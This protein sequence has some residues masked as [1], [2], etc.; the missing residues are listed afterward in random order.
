M[1]Q[2]TVFDS[3]ED[4]AKAL[5]LSTCATLN[6]T[7][8]EYLIVGGWVP[9]I[10]GGAPNLQ[11]PGTRDVDVLFTDDDVER[12]EPAYEALL[13]AGFIPSAKHEFQLLRGLEIG[14]TTFI[15]NVDL[16]HRAIQEDSPEILIDISDFGLKDP[17]D[18]SGKRWAKSIIFPGAEAIFTSHLWSSVQIGGKDLTGKLVKW[19]SRC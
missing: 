1:E 6:S 13:N 19:I 3:F 14:K 11:H 18:P 17:S 10:R 15:F 5:L 7:K 4:A 9:V 8:V 12:V 2:T 16:M